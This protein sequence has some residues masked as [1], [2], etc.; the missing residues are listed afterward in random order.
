MFPNRRL[1]MLSALLFSIALKSLQ[2]SN[3]ALIFPVELVKQNQI[4][5]LYG[6]VP[7]A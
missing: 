1:L 4:K 5:N 6:C 2:Y 3:S 7:H